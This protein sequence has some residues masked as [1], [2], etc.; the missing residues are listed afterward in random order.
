MADGGHGLDQRL[1]RLEAALGD[2]GVDLPRHA[3]SGATEAQLTAADA[4]IGFRLPDDVR[5]FY[6]W[7]N[8][9]LDPLAEAARSP[10]LAVAPGWY[11][12][13]IGQAVEDHLFDRRFAEEEYPDDLQAT[14]GLDHVPGPAE[15]Q[16]LFPLFWSSSDA[17]LD[18]VI[19]PGATSRPGVELNWEATD[20]PVESPG[21][22]SIAELIDVFT[23]LATS[24][25]VVRGLHDELTYVDGRVPERLQHLAG[26]F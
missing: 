16:R 20:I 11:L 9:G 8:G 21:M 25:E 12:V 26:W 23:S 2:L 4:A 7:H 3:A 15:V 1:R 18:A 22:A 10:D 19:E 14:F 6:R 24:G 5:T 13:S 17:T